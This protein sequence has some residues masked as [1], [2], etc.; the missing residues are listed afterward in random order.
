MF[1]LTPGRFFYDAAQ[2]DALGGCASRYNGEMQAGLGRRF[3]TKM[4]A[5]GGSKNFPGQRRG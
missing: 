4:I 3:D 2:L 5:T 1:A